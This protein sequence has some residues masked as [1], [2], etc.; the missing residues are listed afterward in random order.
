MSSLIF[1]LKD[2]ADRDKM[3]GMT[4]IKLNLLVAAWAA[5]GKSVH[6]HNFEY[7]YVDF[8]MLTRVL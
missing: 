6:L 7:C 1:S 2:L 5:L 3:K 8:P 4:F